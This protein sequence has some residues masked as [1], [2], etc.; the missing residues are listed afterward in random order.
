MLRVLVLVQEDVTKTF[1]NKEKASNFPNNI[2]FDLRYGDMLRNAL[3][4]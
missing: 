3:L 1:Q 2:L 4:E